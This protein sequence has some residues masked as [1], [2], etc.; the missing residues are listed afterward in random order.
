MASTPALVTFGV[1][2]FVEVLADKVPVIDHM[3]DVAQTVVRPLAGTVVVA[4]S[5][6]EV[7]PLAATVVGLIVGSTTAG[8]VHLAKAKVRVV[9]NMA[10]V[11]FAAPFISVLEDITALLGSLISVFMAALA[12]LFVLALAVFFWMFYRRMKRRQLPAS[13][14]P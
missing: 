10:S 12:A 3:L 7:S 2:L 5:L 6:E 4:A 9:S 1:A 13:P 11:G 8:G 14:S